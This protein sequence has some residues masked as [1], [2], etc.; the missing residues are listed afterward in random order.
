MRITTKTLST[1][2]LLCL[3]VGA[4]SAAYAGTSSS[5]F[6][7]IVPRFQQPWDSAAQTKASTGGQGFVSFDTIGGDYRMNARICDGGNGSCGA[8]LKEVAQGQG[9]LPDSPFSAG[10]RVHLQL[11]ATPYN[12][13]RVEAIGSWASN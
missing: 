8:E 12:F 10:S 9:A 6:D 7:A 13:V 4:G 3:F 1:A 11:H 5:H 2:A